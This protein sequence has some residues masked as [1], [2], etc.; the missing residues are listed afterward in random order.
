MCPA[1]SDADDSDDDSF[2]DMYAHVEQ[3]TRTTQQRR[4]S[5]K[6][7]APRRASFN[8]A[9]H[10]NDTKHVDPNSS[11]ASKNAPTS[12]H[13]HRNDQQPSG[14]LGSF[15][16]TNTAAQPK[17]SSTGNRSYCSAPAVV[18]DRP[19]TDN[20]YED[21][22]T[23]PRKSTHDSTSRRSSLKKDSELTTRVG[24]QRHITSSQQRVEPGNESSAPV[25]S[26]TG[27]TSSSR[28]S[29]TS[30]TSRRAESSRVLLQSSSSSRTSFRASTSSAGNPSSR[31][32]STTSTYSSRYTASSRQPTNRATL[33][34]SESSSRKLV[35]DSELDAKLKEIQEE[36]EEQ[37][38]KSQEIK[39]QVN[40]S[41]FRSSRSSTLNRESSY[42][43]S[44]D[45]KAASSTFSS[46]NN[47]NSRS[48]TADG[49]TTVLGQPSLEHL[50]KKSSSAD[51][52]TKVYPLSVR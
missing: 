12:L 4:E 24:S 15:L 31:A 34:R 32:A 16:E 28:R 8:N 19:R 1:S 45:T 10:D 51:G 36:Q 13:H 47:N 40:R 38:K 11:K 29:L 48:R 6:G 41:A 2:I 17:R 37:R 5:D 18:S 9:M 22:K 3:R 20:Y 23:G 35:G 30:S 50:P 25:T 42:R 27:T 39:R 21:I 52:N 44:A 7:D 26:T 46:S 14:F 33:S 49:V 43:R